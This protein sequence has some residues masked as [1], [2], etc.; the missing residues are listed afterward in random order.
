MLDHILEPCML[1]E[2]FPATISFS[3]FLW[4]SFW[5]VRHACRLKRV[6]GC[7][8]NSGNK[9]CCICIVILESDTHF[10][11]MMRIEWAMEVD[12]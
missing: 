8:I 6:W 4:E 2:I 5:L 3:F 11:K 10:V 7:K 1:V 9:V 12:H